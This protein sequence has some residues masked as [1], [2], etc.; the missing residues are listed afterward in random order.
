MRLFVKCIIILNA[1]LLVLT[2]NN[3]HSAK[4]VHAD[5]TYF[6]RITSSQTCFYS[7]PDNNSAIFFLPE[8][9]FVELIGDYD[10][11]FY[12][13]K[14]NDIYGYVKKGEVK[15]VKNIPNNPYLV[16]ITF[17]VFVPSG[18]NL[19]S[20]PY[21]NGSVNLIYSIPFL[22]TNF[23]YYGIINGEEAISKKGNIWY[24][25]KYFSNNVVYNGYVYSPLCDSLSPIEKNNEPV[26][27]IDGEIKFDSNNQDSSQINA[28]ENLPQATQTIIIIAISLPCL[29]FIYLLFKP[30]MVAESSNNNNKANRKK[31]KKKIS[32][33]RHSDY[34][35]LDDDF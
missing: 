30:T 18:A 24:Y 20:T 15:A 2:I 34:F 4:Y 5:I 29:L 10:N 17:R 8:T 35:E 22:D 1:F 28:I 6:A 12:Y 9:Y 11:D 13:A 19:R 14:Y 7:S 16:D 33:L 23:A 26:E 3:P 32:K 31:H 27:F 25:C 21:N